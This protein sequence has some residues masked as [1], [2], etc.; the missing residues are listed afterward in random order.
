MSVTAWIDPKS[1]AEFVPSERQQALKEV[2]SLACEAGYFW[3]KDWFRLAKEH[4]VFKAKPIGQ[5]EWVNWTRQDGF[6]EWFYVDIQDTGAP[7][8]YE[9]KALDTKFWRGV[10]QGMDSQ[11][12]WSFKLFAKLRYGDANANKATH[13]G[14]EME[15]FLDV[16]NVSEGWHVTAEA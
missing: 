16:E 1:I 15:R 2:A 3:R 12:E 8:D 5:N 13:D 11:K 9:M 14:L 7:D 10:A 4:E 6:M